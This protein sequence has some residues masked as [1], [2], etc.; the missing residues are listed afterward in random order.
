MD[1]FSFQEIFKPKQESLQVSSAPKKKDINFQEMPSG[2]A[3][4]LNTQA[5]NQALI[6]RFT[7]DEPVAVP[8]DASQNA[9]HLALILSPNF[10]ELELMIRGLE[11]RKRY[12]PVMNKEEIILA[13]IKDHPLNEYGINKI[14]EFLKTYSS[15]EI[16]LGR[17]RLRD[18]YNSVQHVSRSAV[19]LIYKN[20]KNFGMSTQVKQRSAKTYCDA[21]IEFIDANYSRS[22]E[23]R[24]NDNS[25]PTSFEVQGNVDTIT[26]PNKFITPKIREQ[27][28]N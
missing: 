8:I 18:Y 21:I 27:M 23:G 25:R 6:D 1:Q 22:V 15:P 26:D 7:K 10:R 28:K 2:T 5:V 17:K 20:L 13:Q 14:L 16:K 4:A 19:R 11:Y 24:E 9:S 3:E 12:N